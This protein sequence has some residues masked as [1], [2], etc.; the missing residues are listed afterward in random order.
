MSREVVMFTYRSHSFGSS[1]VLFVNGE[2]SLATDIFS[3]DW[4]A[5]RR[6]SQETVERE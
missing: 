5:E 4:Y 3:R 6:L 1:R 2:N